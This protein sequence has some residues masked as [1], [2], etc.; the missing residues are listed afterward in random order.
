MR[1]AVGAN[2][3]GLEHTIQAQEGSISK[4]ARPPPSTPT[5]GTQPAY[6]E[7]E[8]EC[9]C[10]LHAGLKRR[11]KSQRKDAT[12]NTLPHAA[13]CLY[14]YRLKL[15]RVLSANDMTVTN[16]NRHGSWLIMTWNWVRL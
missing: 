6:V 15:K 14:L 11:S 9:G 13:C 8:V 5:Q 7:G 4:G 1:E 3:Q 10:R 12:A 2:R 16:A